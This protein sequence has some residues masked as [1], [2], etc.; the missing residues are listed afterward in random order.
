[1]AFNPKQSQNQ[2]GK[3]DFPI[4]PEGTTPARL[5]RI[6]E[7]GTQ[8]TQYGEMK[9][10]VFMYSLPMHQIEYNGEWKQQFISTSRMKVS[11]FKD[12]KSGRKSTLMKHVDALDEGCEDLRELL[13][14]ECLLTIIHNQN[15]DGTRTYAN[16]DNV[17][18]PMPGMNNDQLDTD[19][20]YFD[21]DNP[22][23]ESWDSLSDYMKN[24]IRTAIDYPGSDVEVI[25]VKSQAE[26]AQ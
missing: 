7:L 25:D 5:A 2:A 20:L 23:A 1:M 26:V 17:S 4:A 12:P 10:V 19:P 16:I 11:A 14:K 13:G 15:Q 18:K 9:Q 6:V 3:K 8:S 22:E 21:F 24:I